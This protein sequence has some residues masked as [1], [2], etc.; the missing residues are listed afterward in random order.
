MNYVPSAQGTGSHVITANY[1]GDSAH[2]DSTGSFTLTVTAGTAA[3]TTPATPTTPSGSAKIWTD[4]PDYLPTDTPTIYGTGFL[5]SANI[6]VSITRPEGTVNAWF[7]QA[8][9]SGGFTTTY[10]TSGLVFGTFTVTTTDGTNTATTTFTDAP[11]YF[12]ITIDAPGI[13]SASDVASTTPVF[14]ITAD[15]QTDSVNCGIGTY[16]K[17]DLGTGGKVCDDKKN[18]PFTWQFLSPIASTTSGKQYSWSSTTV[19]GTACSGSQTVTCDGS[20]IGSGSATYKVQWQ[21]TFTNS[22]FTGD[23]TGTLVTLTPT[24]GTCTAS[25]IN[26]PSG[27]VFCDA[28]TSLGFSFINPV[29][30]SVTGKQY[31][32][33]SADKTSPLSVTGTNTVT[34]TYVVQWKQTFT[35]SG[36]TGDATG[37]LVTLTPTGG[38]CTAA[39]ISTPSGFVFCDASTSLGFTF[40]NPV[41]SGTGGKQYRFVSADKTSPISVSAAN[42]V[43]GTYVTQWQVSFAVLPVGG[44]TTSPSGTAYYDAGSLPISASHNTGYAFSSWSSSTGSITF[45]SSTSASTTATIGGTGTITANFVVVVTLQVTSSSTPAGVGSVSFTFTL[46]SG[47]CTPSSG[48]YSTDESFSCNVGATYSITA[49]DKPVDSSN[50]YK[51]TS[52]TVNTGSLGTVPSG[53][54]TVTLNYQLQHLLTVNVSPGAVGVSNVARNPLGVDCTPSPTTTVGCWY[55][56]AVSVQ[57]TATTP[58]PAGTTQYVFT[59]WSGDLSGS[60][61]PQSVAMS[62]GKTVTA[63][64]QTQYQQTF[65]NSGLGADATG[66]LATLTVTTGSCSATSV[67]APTNSVYCDLNAQYSFS[68]SSTI[69]SSTVTGKQYSLTAQPSGSPVTVSGP[70]SFTG[71]YVTQW[72]VTFAVS[73][74]GGGTTSPTDGPTWYPDGPLSGG[75]QANPSTGYDFTLWSATTTSGTVSFGSTSSASTTA[76]IHGTGTITATFTAQQITITF[77][78]TADGGPAHSSDMSGSSPVLVITAPASCAS[79][80]PYTKAHLST[81]CIV[82][83]GT[84]VTFAYQSPV[85]SS[86]T[87]QYVWKSTAGLSTLQSDSITATTSGTITGAYTSQYQQTFQESGLTCG[88][89]T[90][91][92]VTV[93]SVPSTCSPLPY[94]VFVDTGSTVTYTY[95]T[96]VTSSVTGKQYRLGT[97]AP[98]PAS[99]YTVTS[100]RIRLRE[101]MLLNG[102]YRLPSSRPDTNQ[103]THRG[104]HTM[105]LGRFQ[106][107]P[108][109]TLATPLPRGAA[110][111]DR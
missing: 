95:T 91:T 2:L 111:L 60:T 34:G 77:D 14:Q 80:S 66:V 19:S 98:S 68:F 1:V 15:G 32:F 3:T 108:R 49:V 103:P 46:N 102:R 56:D 100:T 107:P 63:N 82:P 67:N 35:N 109:L 25:S 65:G 89:A 11:G 101:L 18:Q 96:P 74:T 52:A 45:G 70:N 23:A 24:G 42:T 5:A 93:N 36:F 26:T 54:Q 28:G 40:A 37:T 83:Y 48:P 85:S 39:S 99:G 30:S 58:V 22:G 72:Q 43:T 44:G 75:I 78:A 84:T 55:N 94:S 29:T 13:R 97:P 41:T 7:V 64:Y 21:E 50:R 53:G 90:G 6:T 86:L 106:Y 81:Q 105:M 71:T 16:T 47:S 79:G 9:A 62:A 110:A 12:A 73:P 61:N 76:T 4:L 33:S 17:A 104:P 92:V 59:G 51:F 88:D 10:V 87:K 31:K 69:A 20:S 57:L 8:D 27:N 38:T